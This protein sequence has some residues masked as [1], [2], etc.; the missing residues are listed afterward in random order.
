MSKKPSEPGRREFD[1]ADIDGQPV[2]TEGTSAQAIT[3]RPAPRPA[4][5]PTTQPA[6]EDDQDV[7]A[8]VDQS[9]YGDDVE[10]DSDA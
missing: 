7:G 5:Q 10:R 9:H 4:Q 1:H 3:P 6:T 8:P 2:E